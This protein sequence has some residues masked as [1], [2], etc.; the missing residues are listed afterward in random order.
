MLSTSNFETVT[1]NF[2]NYSST[3]KT[4]WTDD[5]AADHDY[6]FIV[7]PGLGL[8]QSD[9]DRNS[10]IKK[11]YIFVSKTN[12]IIIIKI[13][14]IYIKKLRLQ[15]GFRHLFYKFPLAWYPDKKPVCY[16]NLFSCYGHEW[17]KHTQT[18]T[19]TTLV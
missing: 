2:Q 11:L 8:T 14:Y 5:N 17:D 10:D 19:L 12:K 7:P 13:H 1:A 6:K 16:P 4:Q 15:T 18:F 9:Q 3:D